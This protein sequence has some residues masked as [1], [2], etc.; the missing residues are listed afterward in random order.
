MAGSVRSALVAAARA[1]KGA[2]QGL[3]GASAVAAKAFPDTLGLGWRN[4]GGLGS[5]ARDG[6]GFAAARWLAAKAVWA[7]AAGAGQASARSAHRNPLSVLEQPFWGNA[8][9]Q[10]A[11]HAN[12]SVPGVSAV[13]AGMSDPAR[14]W[15]S[16]W[17]GGAS[18]WVFTL[19]VLGGV[20]R[21]TRSGLSMTD[22][23]FS[24]ERPPSTQEEWLEEFAKY[25]ESPEFKRVNTS[26]TVE[27][28][29]FIYWM[30]WAH[31]MWGRGLGLYFLAPFTLFLAKRWLTPPLTRRLLAIF[32]AGGAQGLIGWWMVKSGLE[33]PPKEWDTPRVSPYRLATHLTSAFA[34]FTALFWTFLTLRSPAPLMTKVDLAGAQAMRAVRRRALP[35]AG[36]ISLTA[37]SG[38]FV[39]GMDAGRAYNDFPFMNGQLV[40]TQEYFTS[41]PRWR[42]FFENTAAVQFDHRVLALTTLG[43]VGAFWASCRGLPLP[44]PTR[45]LVSAMLHMTGLQVTLGIAA[46]MT[47]VPVELG[48]L[49]QAGALTLFSIT[50]ALLHTLRASPTL[51]WSQALLPTALL[52]LPAAAAGGTGYGLLASSGAAPL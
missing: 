21:L 46:L 28:F 5:W 10:L 39:A 48:S 43:A 47:H 9:R 16:W 15:V 37:V 38:A 51:S 40:P 27:E 25:K 6:S 26:M 30:E 34:I 36:L 44:R 32:A 20:T 33:E 7:H 11:T 8:R 49:H 17:L 2:G 19:V 12:A 42:N 18:A 13:V 45:T 23:K 31:R 22:W 4:L 14:K 29:K 52:L 41:E 3:A 1:A 35:L 50:L 24:G